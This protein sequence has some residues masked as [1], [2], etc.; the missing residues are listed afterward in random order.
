M[1]DK[2][3]L[4]VEDVAKLA[5]DP[6][7]EARAA[8]AAK[9]GQQLAHPLTDSERRL[10]EDIVRA[11]LQDA[12]SG[13]REALAQS[14]KTNPDVPHDVALTLARDIADVAVPFVQSSPA[15]SDADL[16]DI[17]KES[18]V[19]TQVA[20][21]RRPSVSETVSAALVDKGHEEVVATLVSNDG[22]QISDKTLTAIVE[23]HG[24]SAA[25]AGVM[26][27]RT[28]VPVAIAER[29]VHR[30]F[31]EL[32]SALAGTQTLAEDVVSDLIL[33]A[34]ERAT[35][36]LLPAGTA[37]FDVDALVAHLH[38]NNRLT[39][40]I[41]LRAV[42]MGDV[43]FLEAA[44]AEL[45]TIPL[46]NSRRLI[47]EGGDA[48]L[49]RLLDACKLPNQLLPILHSALEIARETGYD[50]GPNDRER[51]RNRVT[52]R[53]LTMGDNL[54]DIPGQDVDYLIR[55]LTKTAA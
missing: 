2:M 52:E 44:L 4:A 27:V 28:R 50:G 21:A 42:C 53:L 11:F 29:L 5:S 24:S 30:I 39:P 47:E 34:R 25:V 32:W 22:A 1:S 41:I 45:A 54:P 19:R 3:K 23:Q 51:Y 17:I 33:Q 15:L 49:A 40:S 8:T 37:H 14:L 48:G 43:R 36:A 35:V 6:S 26:A 7:S 46:E 13:V 18:E 38:A 10:A 16:L 20:I 55:H 12:V 31:D 9:V